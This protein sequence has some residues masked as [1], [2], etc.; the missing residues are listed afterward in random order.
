MTISLDKAR[1]EGM[2]WQLLNALDKARPIGAIDVL[3]L[4][5][6]RCNYPDAT[7]NELHS[8]L[9]Y[10]GDKNL[11]ILTRYPDGHWHGCL[12]SNGIDVVEYTVN[13]PAGIARPDK[14]WS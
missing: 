10:L 7:P 12:N 8:Q 14:Y 11:V 1:R 5:V 2:R 4:D 6:V 9:D 3:L 13:C